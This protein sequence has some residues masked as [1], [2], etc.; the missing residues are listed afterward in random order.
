MRGV[1]GA[2]KSTAVKSLV[3]TFKDKPFAIHSTDTVIEREYGGIEG[4]RALFEK[5][6][7]TKNFGALGN[8]HKMNQKEVW[9]SCQAGIQNVIVDNTNLQRWEFKPYIQAGEN[10]NYEI[11]IHNIQYGELTA[12]ELADRNSHDVPVEIIEKMIRKFDSNPNMEY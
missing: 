10:F 5:M 8:A 1:S 2:G 4:Y 6:H 12:Q 7:E 11:I 3:E 9:D